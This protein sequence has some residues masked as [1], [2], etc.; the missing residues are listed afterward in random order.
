M[1]QE[2]E[3]YKLSLEELTQ[4]VNELNS[5][6][7]NILNKLD[8]YT[9]K[10]SFDYLNEN[11]FL[12]S[13]I[14]DTLKNINNNLTMSNIGVTET[15][16]ESTKKLNT[17]IDNELKNMSKIIESTKEYFKIDNVVEKD[18]IDEQFESIIE[19]CDKIIIMLQGIA[20]NEEESDSNMISLIIKDKIIDEKSQI[21]SIKDETINLKNICHK[22]LFNNSMLDIYC[23]FIKVELEKTSILIIRLKNILEYNK[24]ILTNSETITLNLLI[25]ILEQQ[26]EE[27]TIS[28]NQLNSF[29]N[30]D[31]SIT[32]VEEIPSEESSYNQD[33]IY[34]ILDSLKN[35]NGTTEDVINKLEELYNSQKKELNEAR[36]ALE[37]KMYNMEINSKEKEAD[38]L[39]YK[40]YNSILNKSFWEARYS[41]SLDNIKYPSA[42]YEQ[43]V[44]EYQNDYLIEHY[45]VSLMA[46]EEF[47]EEYKN[48]YADEIYMDEIYEQALALLKDESTGSVK[49]LCDESTG[50][51]ILD[52][53]AYDLLQD[54]LNEVI[55]EIG[56]VKK[57]ENFDDSLD[58]AEYK[59]SLRLKKLIERKNI[60]EKNIYTLSKKAE[61]LENKDLLEKD[62][63]GGSDDE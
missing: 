55:K 10:E 56:L 26:Q 2:Y 20:F 52:Q 60:I 61:K 43:T 8:T 21:Q 62:V 14:N 37:K 32:P 33:S 1:Y 54:D 16:G 18:I 23:E 63:G 30:V 9:E 53:K 5:L 22:E 39:K 25:E 27:L 12:L 15:L 58:V 40:N 59:K 57:E 17:T 24:S 29:T 38:T 36:E 47:I 46:V 35:S 48:K 4:K 11:S 50:I 3:K 19:L 34:V 31:T 51:S 7:V 42:L 45:N 6:N 41:A 44:K 28:Y 13:N 49:E